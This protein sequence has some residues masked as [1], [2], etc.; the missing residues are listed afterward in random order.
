MSTTPTI[1]KK[2]SMHREQDVAHRAS[3]SFGVTHAYREM[4]LPSVVEVSPLEQLHQNL[5]ILEDLQSRLG[6]MNRELQ[7]LIRRG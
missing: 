5:L 2:E 7:S 1:N 4:R 6:F 3:L